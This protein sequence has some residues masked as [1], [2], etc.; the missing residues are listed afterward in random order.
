MFGI[1]RIDK[2]DVL[3]L[4]L[5]G[6]IDEKVDWKTQFGEVRKNTRINCYNVLRINSIGAKGWTLFFRS[7]REQGICLRFIDISPALVEQGGFIMGFFLP[8][9]VESF[10]VPF[11]CED[12]SSDFLKVYAMDAIKSKDLISL[13]EKCEQCEKSVEADV[14]AKEYFFWL[15]DS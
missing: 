7:L 6:T 4:N 11:Y 2:D 14:I 10:C 9:E 8:E 5:T 13:T 1:S 15:K 3:Y 12:C